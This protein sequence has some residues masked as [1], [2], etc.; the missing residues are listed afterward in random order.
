MKKGKNIFSLIIGLIITIALI[1]VFKFFKEEPR[2]MQNLSFDKIY[3]KEFFN[4]CNIKNEEYQELERIKVEKKELKIFTIKTWIGNSPG[5]FFKILIMNEYGKKLEFLNECGWIC[6]ENEY[7]K[8]YNSINTP[9]FSCIDIGENNKVLILTGFQYGCDCGGGLLTL[10]SLNDSESKVIFN[11]NAELY[12]I[13]KVQDYYKLRISMG[14]Y[15]YGGGEPIDEKNR[16]TPANPDGKKVYDLYIKENRLIVEDLKLELSEIL[17]I[18]DNY[19]L[20]LEQK[21][22]HEI[23]KATLDQAN[24]TLFKDLEWSETVSDIFTK[25]RLENKTGGLSEYTAYSP[26]CKIDPKFQQYN[27][28]E[29]PYFLCLD[30]G[31]NNPV[32]VLFDDIDKPDSQNLIGSTIIKLNGR[33]PQIIF[34]KPFEVLEILENNGAYK[35]RI[36][37]GFYDKH[38]KDIYIKN[39]ELHIDEVK[40][41]IDQT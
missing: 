40:V 24:V 12:D 31:E 18:V 41:D 5:D 14:G 16:R 22:Y 2:L 39:N 10:I 37:Y 6:L 35:L 30:I 23:F 20:K 4:D 7:L 29:N 11:K 28:I 36:L 15:M 38:I 26:W 19:Y 1:L 17:D 34:N 9:Y 21:T 3:V 8:K 27:L 32:V 13:I 33:K 25:I